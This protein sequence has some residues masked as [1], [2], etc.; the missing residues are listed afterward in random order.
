MA[1]ERID[2]SIQNGTNNYTV[3]NICG[4]KGEACRNATP[5]V[6]WLS[7]AFDEDQKSVFQETSS[8]RG[9]YRNTAGNRPCTAPTPTR[10]DWVLTTLTRR[11]WVPMTGLPLCYVVATRVP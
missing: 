10:L 11:A 4:E 9:K 7:M 3:V 5:Q 8:Q 6:D 1:K 2:E